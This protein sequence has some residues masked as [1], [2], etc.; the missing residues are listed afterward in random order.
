MNNNRCGSKA[1]SEFSLAFI[2]YLPGQ[3]SHAC[4]A[5]F[6]RQD[7]REPGDDNPGGAFKTERGI[8]HQQTAAAQAR[9]PFCR[10]HGDFELKDLANA[11]RRDVSL[12]S[13]DRVWLHEWVPQCVDAGRKLPVRTRE[14][15]GET[16][17]FPGAV[18]RGIDQD[19][20][21]PFLRRQMSLER[22]VAVAQLHFYLL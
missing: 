12:E 21:T 18:E 6:A 4:V 1:K 2:R 20:S 22:L 10:Q 9:C 16:P 17:K 19:E 5:R 11:G 8:H 13:P 7:G 15:I 14:T 3:P